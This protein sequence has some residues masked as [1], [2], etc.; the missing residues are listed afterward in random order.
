MQ[1]T[2]RMSVVLRNSNQEKAKILMLSVW[3]QYVSHIINVRGVN[4]S[5]GKPSLKENK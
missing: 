4:K 5:N 2:K 3:P 1:N